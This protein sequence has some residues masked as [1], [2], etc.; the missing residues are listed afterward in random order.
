MRTRT[1]PEFLN[2]RKLRKGTTRYESDVA[3]YNATADDVMRAS[4][5]IIADLYSFSVNC[6]IDETTVPDGRHFSKEIQAQQAA[7]LAGFLN[8]LSFSI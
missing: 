5:I 8:A 6:G 2:S 3:A 7:F 4:G 1:T